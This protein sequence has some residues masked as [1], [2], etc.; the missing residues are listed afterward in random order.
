VSNLF[1]NIT[2]EKTFVSYIITAVHSRILS[3]KL[4]L[5]MLDELTRA[6]SSGDGNLKVEGSP[7]EERPAGERQAAHPVEPAPKLSPNFHGLG[8]EVSAKG[9]P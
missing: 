1:S 8:H 5:D 7:T 4:P 3:A 9:L 2:V 6:A